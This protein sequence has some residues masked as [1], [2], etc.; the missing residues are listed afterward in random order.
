MTHVMLDLETLG[1]R[2][3]CVVLSI[4]AIKFS[5]DEPTAAIE[6]KSGFYRVVALQSAMAAGLKIQANTLLW[7][8]K[9]ND[10]ARKALTETAGITLAAMLDDFDEWFKGSTY[11]W[12]HGASFDPP[13]LEAAYAALKRHAPWD[14][15][16]IRDTRTIYDFK[17]HKIARPEGGKHHALHDAH[18][19]AIE[20]DRSIR[21][22]RASIK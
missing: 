12:G 14:Y 13:V 8:L 19:Q 18:H 20:L 9:Q 22:L 21:Q 11:I 7:W 1:T 10:F 4:G 2:P 3:G 16:N 5:P 6:M 17:H 15:R